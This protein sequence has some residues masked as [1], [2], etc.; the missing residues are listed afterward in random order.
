M[1]A[2][3]AVAVAALLASAEPVRSRVVASRPE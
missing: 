1:E 2:L 3:T